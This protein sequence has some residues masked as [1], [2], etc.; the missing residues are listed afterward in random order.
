MDREDCEKQ[1]YLHKMLTIYL[2]D[3]GA[4][5]RKKC[6]F[7]KIFKIGFSNFG[8]QIYLSNFYNSCLLKVSL[9]ETSKPG[10]M[11]C[12]KAISVM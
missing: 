6:A 2:K 9:K 11:T 5:R 4:I 12:F 10:V 7:F 8:I 1:Q 3:V